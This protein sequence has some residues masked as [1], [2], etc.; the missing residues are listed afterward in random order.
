M[1]GLAQRVYSD[2]EE[3]L[4]HLT[5]GRRLYQDPATFDPNNLQAVV[6]LETSL[7]YG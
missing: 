2:L 7:E 3:A 5:Q 1:L 6:A 4:A